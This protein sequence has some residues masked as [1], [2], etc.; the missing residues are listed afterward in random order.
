MLAVSARF[1]A[2]GFCLLEFGESAHVGLQHLGNL[3]CAVGRLVVFEDGQPP[4][5]LLP[6]Q[7]VNGMQVDLPVSGLRYLSEARRA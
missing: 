1:L 7:T 2:M 6:G 5:D 3:D 4:S